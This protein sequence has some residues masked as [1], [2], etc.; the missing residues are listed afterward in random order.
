[1]DLDIVH[2]VPLGVPFYLSC[3]IISYHADYTWRHGKRRSPCLQMQSSCL[4]LI[5][6]MTEESY[7]K[8]ECVSEEKGYAKV[9]KH[10]QLFKQQIPD[11]GMASAVATQ[12]W[13]SFWMAVAVTAA[14]HA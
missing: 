9:V 6:V 13:L 8:Y 2:L 12:L 1:M 5:P 11:C 7:G 14:A 10:Y 4:H 3:P